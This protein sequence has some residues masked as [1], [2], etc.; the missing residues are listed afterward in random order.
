[1]PAGKWPM[2]MKSLIFCLPWEGD[3]GK[4]RGIQEF[5]GFFAAAL[6]LELCSRPVLSR[7]CSSLPRFWHIPALWWEEIKFLELDNSFFSLGA[8]QGFRT[9]G[10]FGMM[11]NRKA[12]VGIISPSDTFSNL[13]CLTNGIFWVLNVHSEGSGAAEVQISLPPAR[14]AASLWDSLEIPA[15]MGV[16]GSAPLL[17]LFLQLSSQP[18]ALPLSCGFIH[19]SFI[20][21]LFIFF[22]FCS[23]FLAFFLMCS[24]VSPLPFLRQI[25]FHLSVVPRCC[26]LWVVKIHKYLT[27]F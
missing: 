14:G 9:C 1:M 2:V 8:S 3:P 4:K 12:L 16:K 23:C 5:W 11:E 25:C 27:T 10:I 17:E 21:L 20:S 18:A 24:A 22:F 15:G 6:C 13:G 19:L 26:Q 7:G